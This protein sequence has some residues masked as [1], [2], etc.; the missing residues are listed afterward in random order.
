V[1]ILGVLDGLEVTLGVTEDVG[2][3]EIVHLLDRISHCVDVIYVA[4]LDLT[5][6]VILWVLDT[7]ALDTVGVGGCPRAGIKNH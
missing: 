6:R 4:E 3:P 2:L 1:H 7:P 5:V